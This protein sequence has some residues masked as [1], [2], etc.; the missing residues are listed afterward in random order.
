MYDNVWMTVF[1]ILLSV[2][3]MALITG[4]CVLA[5]QRP[6]IYIRL[7]RPAFLL[8]TAVFFI[9][10]LWSIAITNSLLSVYSFIDYSRLAE[11]KMAVDHLRFCLDSV[12]AIYAAAVVY[13]VL[14]DWL[15]KA[16]LWDEKPAVRKPYL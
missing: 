11:A 7:A 4:L 8:V 12:L 13:L 9:L 3:L 2:V 16:V 14:L 10:G 15:A 6:S 1:N 5:Y